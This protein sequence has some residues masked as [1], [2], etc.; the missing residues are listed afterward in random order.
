MDRARIAQVRQI[1]LLWPRL[2]Q[3]LVHVAIFLPRTR[4]A[5]HVPPPALGCRH[6]RRLVRPFHRRPHLVKDLLVHLVKRQRFLLQSRI[7]LQALFIFGKTLAQLLQELP[8]PG[9][10]PFLFL[11]LLMFLQPA[12]VTLAYQDFKLVSRVRFYRQ[13][14]SLP[15]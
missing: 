10:R 14:L 2:F 11:P 4:G 12:F 3:H 7:M 5:R 9:R 6:L 1:D 15:L 8:R 13:L